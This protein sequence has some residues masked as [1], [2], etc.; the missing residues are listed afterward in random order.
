MI[1]APAL[2]KAVHEEA[3]RYAAICQYGD[4]PS[5][6][7]KGLFD[8][9]ASES[10]LPDE[11]ALAHAIEEV[12]WA[13][14]LKEEGRP[15]TPRLVYEPGEDTS[16]H[17]FPE[18][19]RLE[20]EV[21]RKVGPAQGPGLVWD[22]QH[23]HPVIVGLCR[24]R[25]KAG[26]SPGVTVSATGSG[27]VDVTWNHVR[28]LTY[29]AGECLR[30][31]TAKLGNLAQVTQHVARE[32]GALMA[33]FVLPTVQR[34]L[35]QRHGGT[36]WIM[37]TNTLPEGIDLQRPL[38]VD[39]R[40]FRERFTDGESHIPWLESVA[41][42]A[43]VDGAVLMDAELRLLGFGAFITLAKQPPEIQKWIAGGGA[44]LVSAGEGVGGRHRSAAEFCDR[45]KPACAYVVSEDGG[46]SAFFAPRDSI[47]Q[48]HPVVSIGLKY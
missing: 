7:A 20:R 18:P 27:A 48:C 24:A 12:F 40:T 10:A 5:L 37:P 39:P 22:V 35:A 23:G 16:V 30:L 19:L 29:R 36:L 31:S 28:L 47:V 44:K 21:L 14:L 41:E 43:A 45:F 17:V 1:D 42:L 11:K 15:C 3:R 46:V 32:T 13:S 26:R 34:M 9:M 2:A 4:A 38:K 8:R 6:D 25:L 33:H